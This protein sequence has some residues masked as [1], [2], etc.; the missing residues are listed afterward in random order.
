MTEFE[1]KKKKRNKVMNRSQI[2]KDAANAKIQKVI[3]EDV[4]IEI[5]KKID[6]VCEFIDEP[7]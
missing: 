4:A 6:E 1:Q 3:D 2:A 7:I 5:E